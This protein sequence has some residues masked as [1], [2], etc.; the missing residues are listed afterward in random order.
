M[1]DRKRKEGW[2]ARNRGLKRERKDTVLEKEGKKEENKCWN[3]KRWMKEKKRWIESDRRKEGWKARNR[4][5]KR[6][7]KKVL[8]KEEKKE[9]N[10]CW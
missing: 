6:G 3:K 1:S 10:K 5:L 2:K 8:D 4:G 9:E 7:E